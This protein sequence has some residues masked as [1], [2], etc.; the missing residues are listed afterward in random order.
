VVERLRAH[1]AV[2]CRSLVG[3][4][5]GAHAATPR[6]NTSGRSDAGGTLSAWAISATSR[7]VKSRSPRSFRYIVEYEMPDLFA[8]HRMVRS[9]LSI[10]ASIRVAV[11]S[12]LVVI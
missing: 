2:S 6:V 10:A 9:S 12:W 7:T 3:E 8:A 1:A 4:D 5:L 11:L